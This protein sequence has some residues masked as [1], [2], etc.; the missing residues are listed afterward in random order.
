M[1]KE[2][3]VTL[4]DRNYFP[5]LQMLY[6]SVQSD[7]PVPI[8][9]FDAGLTAEQKRWLAENCSAL[10][11]SPLP[12]DGIIGEI[13]ATM[14]YGTLPKPG[15]RVWPIWIC[16]FLISSAP[17]ERTFWLDSDIVVLRNLKRLFDM[18][19]EGPVFTPENHAPEVTANKAE[20]YNLLPI[21]RAFDWTKPAVNGGVSGWDLKRDRDV[22]EDY[23]YPIRQ[24][25]RDKRIRDAISW[26][27]QGALIWA[28]QLNELA[29][30][31]LKSWR[32]N[33]CVRHTQAYKKVYRWDESFLERVREDVPETVANLLHWNGVP[34]PWPMP[35]EPA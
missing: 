16:P 33:L 4:A 30:R 9:C 35:L 7:Y 8:V 29:H 22:L 2:G 26:W 21:S 10:H 34:V 24:A 32:W 1:G 18:L 27:D 14:G 11:V 31:V 15:K 13:K 28:I 19:E 12:Q 6:A 17:F 5:G 25:C 20:L 3:I 23:K